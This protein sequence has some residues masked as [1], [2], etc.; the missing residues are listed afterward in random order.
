MAAG[1]LNTSSTALPEKCAT[2][3]P[4]ELTDKLYGCSGSLSSAQYKE[5]TKLRDMPGMDWAD[6]RI[7]LSRLVA[8]VRKDN[9]H[10]WSRRARTSDLISLAEF[11]LTAR[12]F[13]FLGKKGENAPRFRKELAD[14]VRLFLHPPLNKRL[15]A[16]AKNAQMTARP[17][18]ETMKDGW[19]PNDALWAKVPLP[20]GGY[21]RIS[22]AMPVQA[23]HSLEF[24][25]RWLAEKERR[26]AF[27]D[28]VAARI[29]EP[30]VTAEEYARAAGRVTA[31]EYAEA[32]F[33]AEGLA[34]H[35]RQACRALFRHHAR[36]PA[37]SPLPS[38]ARARGHRAMVAMGPLNAAH[39]RRTCQGA[40]ST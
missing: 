5:A 14:A 6:A 39:R 7:A 23:F 19:Q 21:V 34:I 26:R 30:C 18:T 22:E 3:T 15:A 10:R 8:D 32:M 12:G 28:D 31:E 16:S 29:C 9:S 11:A 33:I 20:D 38:N 13:E 27:A 25:R 1:E 35:E 2:G 17:I 36:N 24:L 37:L 40:D 4:Q